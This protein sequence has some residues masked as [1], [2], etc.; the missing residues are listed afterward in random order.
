MRVGIISELP[1]WQTVLETEE[2]E[3]QHADDD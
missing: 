2:Q 3:L 1:F